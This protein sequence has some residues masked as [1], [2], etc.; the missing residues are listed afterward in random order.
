M[1]VAAAALMCVAAGGYFVYSATT[2]LPL[3]IVAATVLVVGAVGE[4]VVTLA[5]IVRA[6]RSNNQS[7]L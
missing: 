7:D 5:I 2:F 1:K 3:Q 6:W 4:M